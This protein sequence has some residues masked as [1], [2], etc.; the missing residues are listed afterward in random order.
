MND[1]QALEEWVLLSA[2]SNS[3]EYFWLWGHRGVTSQVDGSYVCGVNESLSVS[4]YSARADWRS[5]G[6]GVCL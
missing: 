2:C 5:S 6:Y 4:T 3:V 1:R